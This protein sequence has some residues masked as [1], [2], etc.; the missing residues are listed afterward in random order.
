MSMDDPVSYG[1]SAR[2]MPRNL[3]YIAEYALLR[4]GP[5]ANNV[6]ESAAFV[7]SAPGLDRPDIQL[8]FQSAK[9]PRPSFPFPI[10]HGFAAS[11][12][13]LYPRSRGR[14]TLASSTTPPADGKPPYVSHGP[15]YFGELKDQFVRE[16]GVWKFLERRGSIQMKFSAAPG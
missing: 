13:G 5:L 10:G 6:F 14:L 15:I 12:V 7:K 16:Q 1:I 2:A 8:V 4:H 3:L 11:P 9:R